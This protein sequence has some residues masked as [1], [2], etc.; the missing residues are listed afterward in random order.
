MFGIRFSFELCNTAMYRQCFRRTHQN[1]RTDLVKLNTD[2]YTVCFRDG[3]RSVSSYENEVKNSIR[4][5]VTG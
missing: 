2:G 4:G 5:R 1:S 3:E